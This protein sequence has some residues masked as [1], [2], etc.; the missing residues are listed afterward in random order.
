MEAK[1]TTARRSRTATAA[2]AP[3]A[4]KKVPAKPRVAKAS[5][6]ARKEA[7]AASP[8]AERQRL[9]EIAAYFRAERRGFAPGHDW[10]DWLEA[11]AEIEA[12]PS[13]PAVEKSPEAKPARR[14]KKQPAAS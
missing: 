9:I 1:K 6:P 7:A 3:A 14:S 13:E 10:A 11:E 4:A 12:Q 8:P 5:A 2:A